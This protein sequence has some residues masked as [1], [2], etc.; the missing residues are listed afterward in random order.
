MKFKVDENMP[1]EAAGILRAAGHEADTVEEEGLAGSEDSV[2]ALHV[3]QE[4]RALI[5]LDLDFS[6]IRAYPPADYHGIIILR[7]KRQD[8]FTVLELVRKFFP[9]LTTENLINSLWIVEND[10]VRIR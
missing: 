3:Q 7:P 1:A 6:D 2:L 5:T 9:L 4:A 10:R 8:K